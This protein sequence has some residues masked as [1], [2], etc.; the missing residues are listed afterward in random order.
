MK[1]KPKTPPTHDFLSGA[2]RSVRHFFLGEPLDAA[3]KRLP[4][5]P[6]GRVKQRFLTHARYALA[7]IVLGLFLYGTTTSTN[8]APVL[9]AFAWLA[10]IPLLAAILAHTRRLPRSP[11]AHALLLVALVVGATAAAPWTADLLAKPNPVYAIL[12]GTADLVLLWALNHWVR[13][14]KLHSEGHAA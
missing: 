7:Y 6:P 10:L 9:W 1:P 14:T 3:R 5:R 11:K 4:L 12:A 2:R 13:L 8:R